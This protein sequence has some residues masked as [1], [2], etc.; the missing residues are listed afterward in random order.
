MP[1]AEIITIGTEILLGEIV[2]TNTR[3][4]ART[5][6]GMGVDLY[7]TITIGDNAERIAEAIRHSMQRAD[8]VITTGGLG[9]TVDDPTREAVA[10]AAGVELEFREDLWEQVVAVISRYGRKPSENQK[11]QA[12]IPKGA[13]AIPNPVGTAPCFIVET[14]RNAVVS[15][16]GVPNE[17]EHILHES[18]IPYLQKRFNLDEIIKIRVLHCA[19]L[20]EGMIDEKIADLEMLSNPTV[21][22]AAHTGVVDIRI[23]A[24]AKTEAEADRM[25]ADIERQIQEQLGDVVFGADEDKLEDVVLSM[26]AKRGWTLIGVESGLDGLLARKIP[27][28]VSLSDLSPDSLLAALRAARADSNAAAALGVAMYLEERA[29]ELALITPKGEKTHRITYG[30]PPRSLARWSVN[31]ALDWLRRRAMDPEGE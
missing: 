1:S 30:G 31:L 29:A 7:R 18:I 9:P 17:M 3:Y 15:L 25:I 4:I 16:P 28:T 21:G 10:K 11:R 22:L 19:G 24:K 26:V 12:Y 8:I 14:E 20:G 27:H 2:D 6:R 5:L 13:L 23:A